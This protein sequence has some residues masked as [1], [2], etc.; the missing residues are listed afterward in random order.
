MS[1]E[2]VL[3][4]AVPEILTLEEWS[5]LN[6]DVD[7]ELID[8]HLEEEEVPGFV[9]EFLVALLCR[10]F[11]GWIVPRGGLVGGS[12]AKFAIGEGRGRKPDLTIYLPGTPKP[13]RYGL[14][15]QPPDIAVEIISPR[16]RDT[17]R[18]RVDK[19]ADYAAFGIRYYWLVDP[20]L[21]SVEILELGRDGRYIHALGASTGKIDPVPGCE[22]LVLDLDELWRDA[23]LLTADESEE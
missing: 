3:E 17:R 9:H 20:E 12:D 16:P 10:L 5:E 2:A 21:R 8:G 1:R 7:G 22:G 11:I 4:S 6:E 13:P 14:I 18:D 15:R 23:D 19:L